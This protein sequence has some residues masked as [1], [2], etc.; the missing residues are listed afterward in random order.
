M[1]L[2]IPSRGGPPLDTPAPVGNIQ[3]KPFGLLDA[4]GSPG[5]ERKFISDHPKGDKRTFGS[6]RACPSKSWVLVVELD[7]VSR[8]KLPNPPYS[9]K[10][11]APVRQGPEFSRRRVLLAR[12]SG[13]TGRAFRRVSKL[14]RQAAGM[15]WH[16][17]R[18]CI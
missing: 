11:P 18:H 15:G 17:T 5:S 6:V 9:R 13:G 12:L 14:C 16:S 3:R 1:A 7:K 10:F 4:A 8:P 2:G